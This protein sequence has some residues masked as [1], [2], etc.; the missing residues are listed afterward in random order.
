[1]HGRATDDTNMHNMPAKRRNRGAGPKRPGS[2]LVQADV[3]VSYLA[4]SSW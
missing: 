1:M 2:S 4:P 3:P